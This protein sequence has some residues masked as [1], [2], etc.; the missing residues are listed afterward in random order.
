MPKALGLHFFAEDVAQSQG[1][2]AGCL[3]ITCER[4][5]LTLFLVPKHVVHTVSQVQ[6]LKKQA[7]N[8]KH[9][10]NLSG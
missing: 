1:V 6:L 10:S 5:G 7:E 9:R 8:S 2:L 4:K 3:D